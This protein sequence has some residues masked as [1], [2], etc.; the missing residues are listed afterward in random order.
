MKV[1]GMYRLLCSFKH[2]ITCS[3]CPIIN[4]NVESILQDTRQNAISV[5]PYSSDKFSFTSEKVQAT[6]T[7]HDYNSDHK[8]SPCLD[9]NYRQYKNTD[10]LSAS[11]RLDKTSSNEIWSPG[12]NP[13]DCSVS[14]QDS[15]AHVLTI[16]EESCYPEGNVD[17]IEEELEDATTNHG[18]YQNTQ[19][20]D[21]DTEKVFT[22][23]YIYISILHAKISI[24]LLKTAQHF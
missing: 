13:S 20:D 12:E 4:A 15:I 10:A 19:F 24:N 6:M 16:N 7:K 14:S 11:N 21:F 5:T 22:K 2:I 17:T 8:K 23:V 18:K 3:I 1:A 9:N